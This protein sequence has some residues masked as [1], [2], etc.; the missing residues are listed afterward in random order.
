MNFHTD[1]VRMEAYFLKIE[2]RS[3][4]AN[5]AI[6]LRWSV[7]QWAATVYGV[8]PVELPSNEIESS[9]VRGR[10]EDYCSVHLEA[11]SSLFVSFNIVD[12]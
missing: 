11:T 3:G 2:K 10:V 12:S 5:P 7:L 1:Q 9:P 4:Y 6:H 8:F